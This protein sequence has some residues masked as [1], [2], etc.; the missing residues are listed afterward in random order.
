MTD[1]EGAVWVGPTEELRSASTPFGSAVML[2]KKACRE[3]EL[4][5]GRL[6]QTAERD[7]EEEEAESDL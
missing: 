4:V 1:R 6:E 2:C 5:S 3:F 7:R